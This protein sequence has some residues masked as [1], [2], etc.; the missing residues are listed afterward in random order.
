MGRGWSI[1]MSGGRAAGVRDAR[2]AE[3][4]KHLSRGVT[5]SI[6]LVRR[7]PGLLGVEVCIILLLECWQEGSGKKKRYEPEGRYLDTSPSGQDVAWGQLPHLQVSACSAI[8]LFQK[9]PGGRREGK[10][11]G[12]INR[13]KHIALWAHWS[14]KHSAIC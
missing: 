7:K 10:G 2:E 13:D 9:H 4:P 1:F 11:W 12:G 8:L 14:L 5:F 3:P 6:H